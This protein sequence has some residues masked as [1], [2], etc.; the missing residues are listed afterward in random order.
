MTGGA[1]KSAL[2]GAESVN[3]H[4]VVDYDVQQIHAY[5]KYEKKKNKINE[6]TCT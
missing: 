5:L 2:A 1:S 4:L 3:V 6:V